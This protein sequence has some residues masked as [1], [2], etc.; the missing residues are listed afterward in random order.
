M[1][2]QVRQQQIQRADGDEQLAQRNTERDDHQDECDRKTPLSGRDPACEQCKHADYTKQ[3]A[4]H[5]EDLHIADEIRAV[6][7]VADLLKQI[8]VM[9][10]VVPVIQVADD[11]GKC[12]EAVGIR[13]HQE[14]NCGKQ[15]GWSGQVKFHVLDY[16]A[17][18]KVTDR[19]L[20]L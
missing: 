16:I 2:F 11:G 19:R 13:Q 14:R 4:K 20:A 5:A 1:P 7:Q 3:Q 6:P 15:K 12:Q 17:N 9:V 8:F 10:I 18:E